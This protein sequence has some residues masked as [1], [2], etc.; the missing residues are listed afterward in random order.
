MRS[1]L[2]PRLFSEICDAR[3]ALG[4]IQLGRLRRR[5]DH[6]LLS[7]AHQTGPQSSLQDALSLS[8]SRS[9]IRLSTSH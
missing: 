9:L 5:I 8:R 4:P 1:P 7:Q 3:K 2:G 6:S